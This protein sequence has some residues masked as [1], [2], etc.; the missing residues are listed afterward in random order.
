MPHPTLPTHFKAVQ[1]SEEFKKNVENFSSTAS[2]SLKPDLEENNHYNANIKP[3]SNYKANT[4]PSNNY[5]NKTIAGDFFHIDGEG[6]LKRNAELSQTAIEKAN[7]L[8]QPKVP[9]SSPIS[10]KSQKNKPCTQKSLRAIMKNAKETTNRLMAQEA[11]VPE[12][13]KHVR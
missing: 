10:N 3:T 7:K 9:T 11:N 12:Q 1:G 5:E 8:P 2:K 4:M 13:N 6:L